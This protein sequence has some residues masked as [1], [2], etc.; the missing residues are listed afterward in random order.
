MVDAIVVTHNSEETIG[1][2]LSSLAGQAPRPNVI[3]VDTESTDETL[4]SVAASG[5]TVVSV[6]NR[7]FGAAC[8]AGAARGTGELLFFLNPDATL[9]AN[10]LWRL[11]ATLSDFARRGRAVAAGPPL[12]DG[13]IE[14]DENYRLWWYSTSLALRRGVLRT[15][16]L[17]TL[18]IVDGGMVYAARR[19]SGAAMLMR[20]SDFERLG[21]FD[22]RFFLYFEDS[23]LSVRARELGVE[24][25]VDPRAGVEHHAGH[26]TGSRA[27]LSAIQ[28]RSNL[29][30]VLKHGGRLAAAL[31]ALDLA[32]ATLVFGL[33]ELLRGDRNAARRR[34]AR[35]RIL[36]ET[37]RPPLGF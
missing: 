9:S 16:T 21:G 18:E 27:D 1:A 36:G 10:A 7:G 35:M 22:E 30:F 34:F 32:A 20:R 4:A 15:P 31:C 19:L 12:A 28:A 23:D 25:I 6:A 3:V 14:R 2:C 29:W 24:L 37:F 26:S 5:P 13:P 8:N 11:T 33:A 17:R